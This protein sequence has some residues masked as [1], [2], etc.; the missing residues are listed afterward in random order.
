MGPH[1]SGGNRGIQ[2]TNSAHVFAL[3]LPP[4]AAHASASAAAH[5]PGGSLSISL[6]FAF[7]RQS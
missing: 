3:S 4:L 2:A 6:S 7:P 5:I 1:V